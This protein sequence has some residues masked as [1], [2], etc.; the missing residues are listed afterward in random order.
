LP[1]HQRPAAHVVQC[2]RECDGLQDAH[3]GRCSASGRHGLCNTGPCRHGHWW[4]LVRLLAF[5]Q[6]LQSFGALVAA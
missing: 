3:L 4:Q 2:A 5:S 6:S 1:G